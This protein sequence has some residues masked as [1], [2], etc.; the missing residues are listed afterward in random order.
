MTTVTMPRGSILQ[1]Q[2]YDSSANGGDG[3]LKYNKVSE[4][5]RSQFD[6]STDRIEKQQRMSNGTLRKFFIADKKTFTLSWDMLPSYRTFTVD[7]AWGAEDL[8]TF[9]SSA[10]GQSSFNIRVNLAKDGT[11]QESANYEQYNVV[12]SNC[13]FTVLKRGTQPF[14]DVSITLVEV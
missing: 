10:E 13:S 1:I 5:N 7:G 12:F 9:Y 4:H 6:I 14:W 8:R 2:G 11:N 3:S